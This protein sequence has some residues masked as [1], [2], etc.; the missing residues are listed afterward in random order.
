M[1]NPP[2]HAPVRALINLALPWHS[3]AVEVADHNHNRQAL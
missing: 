3:S 1:M 2:Y